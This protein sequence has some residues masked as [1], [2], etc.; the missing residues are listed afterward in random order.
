M[1][2]RVRRASGV[3]ACSPHRAVGC[4][5]E[6]WANGTFGT[7]RCLK[8][9]VMKR[10]F[11]TGHGVTVLGGE[12]AFANQKAPVV[13]LGKARNEIDRCK[14]HA[15]SL[16]LSRLSSWFELIACCFQL[17]MNVINCM[18]WWRFFPCAC[19]GLFPTLFG[20]KFGDLFRRHGRGLFDRSSFL[21][22]SR[23]GGGGQGWGKGKVVDCG[24]GRSVCCS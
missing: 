22:W 6:T 9:H 18:L 21:V 10:G 15:P 4:A 5:F 3:E 17:G 23:G 2:R 12:V 13:G 8:R 20:Q 24:G 1:V 14:H 11:L 16:P 7:A 19:L